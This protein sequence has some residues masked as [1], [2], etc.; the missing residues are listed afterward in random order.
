MAAVATSTSLRE[1][2][3]RLGVPRT[4]GS[5]AHIARRIK[6]LEIDSS[7]FTT[8]RTEPAPLPV[9]G[10]PELASAF[11]Q[12]RSMAELARRLGLPATARTRKHLTRQLADHRLDVTKLGHRRLTL[13]EET[14][15]RATMD[16][17]SLIGVIRTLGLEE[18]NS[19]IRRVR[20]AL[21]VYGVDTTHFVRRAWRDPDP[22]PSRLTSPSRILCQRQA[23]SARIGGERLRRAL[24]ATGVAEKCAEC[25]LGCRWRNKPLGLEVDHINGDWRDNRP[26]NLRLLCPNC[27]ATTPTYCRKKSSLP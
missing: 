13:D 5:H 26:H 27:H 23:G 2:L 10:G 3:D 20:R 8:R 1:V 12:A 24:I 6:A 25:G 15:R 7:H 16:C 17:T 21:D 14:L 19:N 22:C 4:G 11:A 9:V 18:S